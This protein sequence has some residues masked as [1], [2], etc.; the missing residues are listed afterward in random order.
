MLTWSVNFA[1]QL[2][3]NTK[4]DRA[5]ASVVATTG[6]R[7]HHGCDKCSCTRACSPTCPS[8]EISSCAMESCKAPALGTKFN[9]DP[10]QLGFFLAQVW[11]YMWEYGP[12]IATQGVVHDYG[13][14]GAYG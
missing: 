13:A 10:K 14:G 9:G 12:E 8:C 5:T 11:T 1:D 4:S 3:P 6:S 7:G 2:A